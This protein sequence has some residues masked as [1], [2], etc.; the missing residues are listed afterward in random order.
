MELIIVLGFGLM[1]RAEAAWDP[2]HDDYRILSVGSFEKID[3]GP[4]D[5]YRVYGM[6]YGHLKIDP[7]EEVVLTI[8]QDSDLLV[9]DEEDFSPQVPFTQET[10]SSCAVT[11]VVNVCRG[12]PDMQ[13]T[14]FKARTLRAFLF[15][16]FQ[17]YVSF[18]FLLVQLLLRLLVRPSLL[19]LIV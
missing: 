4:E 19:L 7:L 11:H 16:I 15:S 9:Q 8:D 18:G 17:P 10:C 3:L 5:I 1:V 12:P 14:Y 13:N 6:R 2:E